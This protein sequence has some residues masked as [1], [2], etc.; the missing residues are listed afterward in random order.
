MSPNSL[1][2]FPLFIFAHQKISPVIGSKTQ[3]IRGFDARITGR[4][5]NLIS[6]C[7]LPV[8]SVLPLHGNRARTANARARRTPFT[9]VPGDEVSKT[10]HRIRDRHV[11]GRRGPRRKFSRKIFRSGIYNRFNHLTKKNR[12]FPPC[13]F[14][15]MQSCVQRTE[16]R[17]KVRNRTPNSC[18]R[19]R[20]SPAKQAR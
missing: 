17:D 9:A 11:R 4:N 6:A 8:F 5:R 3:E 19:P 16:I 7:Y 10:E 15:C 18:R 20:V 13:K 12:A 1:S 14:A 2:R